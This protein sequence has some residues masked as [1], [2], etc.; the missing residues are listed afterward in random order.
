[1]VSARRERLLADLPIT[2]DRSGVEEALR[3]YQETLVRRAAGHTPAPPVDLSWLDGKVDEALAD[4]DPDAVGADRDR[5]LTAAA[6]VARQT[7]ETDAAMYLGA[8]RRLVEEINPRAAAGRQAAR[9]LQALEEPVAADVE[10]V[11]TELAEVV[12]GSGD[13]TPELRARARAAVHRT[14]D[15]ARVAYRADLLHAL[16][17]KR[18]Y[19]VEPAGP[20]RLQVSGAGW[21]GEHTAV[22]RLTR[23]GGVHHMLTASSRARGDVDA[24]REASRA[25][26]LGR[27]VDDAVHDM[28]HDGVHGLV[29][30]GHEVQH[31]HG[32]DDF[33]ADGGA[34]AG[35]PAPRARTL[36]H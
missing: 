14:A 10:G 34:A 26:E 11:T 17:E 32:A 9:W 23:D 2:A 5:A 20:G 7:D 35:R 30:H 27:D 33:H 36:G 21:D 19:R 15:L 8:L 13:L 1:V 16:L 31:Q 28:T 22:V 25:A 4:L 24:A 29:V 6:L 3:R 18:G 12:A